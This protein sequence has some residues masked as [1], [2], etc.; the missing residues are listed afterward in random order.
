MTIIN[1]TDES[2][3]TEVDFQEKE[4][5]LASIS[6]DTMIDNI[7]DQISF[8]GTDENTYQNS[9]LF[10]YFRDRIDY[11]RTRYPEDQEA[12]TQTNEVLD[13]IFGAIKRKYALDIVFTDSIPFTKKLDFVEAMY[14]FFIL[15][16][17]DRTANFYYS[18]VMN[19]LADLR[20]EGQTRLTPTD[21][22]NL[23]YKSI[24]ESAPSENVV[25][26]Y[27]LNDFLRAI[28][29]VDSIQVLKYMMAGEEEELN[30]HL[31]ATLLID[32]EYVDINFLLPLGAIIQRIARSNP[33]EGM[34]KNRI[35]LDLLKQ[36]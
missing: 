29:L 15:G 11:I 24:V 12:I 32:E 4:N 18:Y 3:L 9:S 6:E 23:S 36:A 26:I 31:V 14:N 13:R 19:N 2:D 16:I 20:A 35:I 22:K 17:F 7:I 8:L 10:Q 5:L 30:N 21:L 33:V 25:V 27:F 1:L 34:D 28:D